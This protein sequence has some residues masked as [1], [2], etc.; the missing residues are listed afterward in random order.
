MKEIGGYIEFEHFHGEMLHGDGIKLDC[1][2]SCLSYL[3][4]TK[5]I[6][7]V[8]IPAFMCDAVF[9]ICKRYDVAM[10]LYEV[11][12]DLKPKKVQLKRG[13]YLY[14][15]NYYGQLSSKEIKQYH[16]QYKNVIVDNTQAY[17]EEPVE[18]AD[19]IYTCRKY[20]G[21]P[22]GGILFTDTKV[23][24]NI[25]QSESFNQMQ[26]L[27]GRFERTASEFYEQSAINN[28]RFE[29]QPTLRMSKL[30]ENL[31]HGIDY[32]FVKNRREE[33][34]SYLHKR[35][36]NRN[37]LKLI[38]PAGPFAY[39]FM[40]NG[41]AAE[42]R[43]ELAKEKIYIPVLWPNVVKDSEVGSIEYDLAMNIL[44]L[45][46]DQRYNLDDMEYMSDRIVSLL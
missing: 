21:V 3:I 14:L 45:P 9:D 29:G 44:P 2:R 16:D 10:S 36:K 18:G 39:P 8:L 32:G 41:K 23:K 13:E 1:G 26:Y 25:P 35:L 12:Y 19:T 27:L 17:F 40:V 7:K 33:N 37:R 24:R 20:F 22:D 34:Y 6:R 4:E 15:A 28:D 5:N 43:K 42:I 38:Q 31:L 46:C 11:G 30:T